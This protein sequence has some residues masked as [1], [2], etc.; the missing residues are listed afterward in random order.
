MNKRYMNSQRY[1][2]VSFTAIRNHF[3]TSDLPE[4]DVLDRGRRIHGMIEEELQSSEAGIV[5]EVNLI[6]PYGEATDGR[7]VILSGHIDAINID[8]GIIYEIKSI[9][10]FVQ[11]PEMVH[12]QLAFYAELY[13]RYQALNQFIPPLHYLTLLL[14][15]YTLQGMKIAELRY[16]RRVITRDEVFSMRDRLRM[17]IDAYVSYQLHR[18]GR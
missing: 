15:T 9:S 5:R 12:L 11:Y 18:S 17:H 13:E 2:I 6:A 10:Y 7:K 1:I 14:Y 8:R 3:Y 16:E 4:Q